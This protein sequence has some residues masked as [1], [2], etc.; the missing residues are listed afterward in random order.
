M[1]EPTVGRKVWY[2]PFKNEL[3]SPYGMVTAGDQPLDATIV[4]VWGPR[5]VN[6]FVIDASGKAFACTSRTLLQDD[7]PAPKDGGYA[8]WMPFQ[9]GQAAKTEAA[10][11]LLTAKAARAV[12]EGGY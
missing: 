11:S 12:G 10:E 3:L 6:L 7:D 2:R 5:C 9:K 8:E 1:M 4:A